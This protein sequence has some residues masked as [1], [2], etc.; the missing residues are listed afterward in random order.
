MSDA[1]SSSPLSPVAVVGIG[2]DG[3]TGLSG[4]AREVLRAAEVII[5]GHR[6]LRL[7]PE[8][9]AAERVAWP[10]PLRPAVP[11][12]LAAHA[13]RRVAVLASGDPMFYGIGRTLAEVAEAGAV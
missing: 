3:W 7:L 9:C 10:S 2:A 12:L 6:Q 8:E 13:G 1:G 11:G 5:G 4:G